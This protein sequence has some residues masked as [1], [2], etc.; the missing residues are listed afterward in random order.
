MHIRGGQNL[1]PSAHRPNKVG[2]NATAFVIMVDPRLRYI[3]A[4]MLLHKIVRRGKVHKKEG[5]TYGLLPP[6]P[7]P[8]FPYLLTEFR[9]DFVLIWNS[10]T[11][12]PQWIC[13][14]RTFISILKI[15]LTLK[16]KLLGRRQT[17][18]IAGDA[19]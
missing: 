6:P 16:Q 2:F 5:E 12:E 14:K 15:Y 3:E 17:M 7:P 11:Y 4:F 13:Q 9:T 1:D 10:F 19:Q 8:S 18:K